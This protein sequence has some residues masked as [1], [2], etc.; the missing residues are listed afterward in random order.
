MIDAA[1]TKPP[2]FDV[3]L[4]HSSAASRYWIE[5]D[6]TG[7]NDHTDHKRKNDS[8]DHTDQSSPEKPIKSKAP[9]KGKLLPVTRAPITT[10]TIN[11]E[12][13]DTED[14]YEVV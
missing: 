1:V 5:I 12:W 11:D 10:I 2:P 3:I 7:N 9:D 13:F 14:E 4:G 6:H 8:S